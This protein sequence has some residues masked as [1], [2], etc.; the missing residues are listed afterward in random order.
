MLL[1]DCCILVVA[2][3]KESVFLIELL[4]I[5]GAAYCWDDLICWSV[6]ENNMQSL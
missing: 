1:N 6:I 3:N 4:V 2:I 5:Y